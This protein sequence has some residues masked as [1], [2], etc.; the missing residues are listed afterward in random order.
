MK[1]RHA[2]DNILPAHKAAETT[3]A[4]VH[5]K[6]ILELVNSEVEKLPEKCRLIFRCSRNEGLSVKQIAERFRLSPKTV[7]NQLTKALNRLKPLG[8]TFFHLLLT[9]IAFF[10]LR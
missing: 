8:R 9:A 5:Y 10:F 7:E 6:R 1:E 3:E 2:L 4:S